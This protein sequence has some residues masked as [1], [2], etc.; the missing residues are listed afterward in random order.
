MGGKEEQTQVHSP[1]DGGACHGEDK[2]GT[3]VVAKVE[4]R[5]GL[6][7]GAG[8]LLQQRTHGGGAGGVAPCQPQG[9]GSSAAAAH[10]EEGGHDGLQDPAQPGSQSSVDQ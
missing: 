8:A 2:G 4:E 5:L 6:F 10:V 7:Q 9:Q 3:G 1:K